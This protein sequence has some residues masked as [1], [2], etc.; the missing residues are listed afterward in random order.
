VQH[1]IRS[2]IIALMR[3]D[4]VRR[5]R[6]VI[7][8][9]Q[10]VAWYLANGD[11]LVSAS[12]FLSH[13]QKFPS[14]RWLVSARVTSIT[15]IPYRRMASTLRP[16]R[17]MQKSREKKSETRISYLRWCLRDRRASKGN[18]SASFE[19]RKCHLNSLPVWKQLIDDIVHVQ[20]FP[21]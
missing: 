3:N 15:S 16:R 5:Y 1:T 14:V 13:R 10:R 8:P 2:V 6:I 7:L 4:V 17:K 12:L 19:M 21:L 11:S 9:A 20:T 18:S